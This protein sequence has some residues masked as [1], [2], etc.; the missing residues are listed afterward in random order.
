MKIFKKFPQWLFWL[1]VLSSLAV[2][3]L[4]S[5]G[6]FRMHDDL[7]V[8]RTYQ[9]H[10][11]VLD[12]QI[13]CRWVPDMGYGYGYPLF[14]YYPP[15]PYY[16]GE[17]IH[18]LGFDYFW[19]VK[20]VFILGF[21]ASGILMYLFAREFFG[22]LGGLISALF[23]IYA[24]YHALDIYVR[25]AMNEFW[26]LAWFPGI[27]WAAYKL[28]KEEKKEWLAILAFFWALLFMSH[29][30]MVMICAPVFAFWLFFL[31]FYF[32]KW[33]LLKQL[34]IA[35]LW[36][37]GLAGFFIIPTLLEKRF[38]HTETLVIGY[39]NY[40][41]HFADLNQMFISR[42]WGF[43]ASLWGPQDGMAFSVGHFHWLV[44]LLV[45]LFTF[46]IIWKNKIWKKW[47]QKKNFIWWLILLM[48]IIS[49]GSC[50]M[51]HYKSIFIW[52]RIKILEFAQFPWRFLTLATFSL[53]FLSGGIVLLFQKKP[54]VLLLITVLLILGVIF[55]NKNYFLPERQFQ[56]TAEEKF[57]GKYWMLQITA[58]IF[59]YLPVY[60][61]RPPGDPAPE[62]P[63][64]IE[65]EGKI[66]NWQ[67]GTNWAKFETEIASEKAKIRVPI[68]YYP[69]W[70]IWL[71]NEKANFSY[72]NELGL[73]TFEAEKGNHQVMIHLNNTPLRTIVNFL[74]IVS[75]AGLVGF[76]LEYRHGRN[77]RRDARKRSGD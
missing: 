6:Y 30:V 44:S 15:M 21:L 12:K 29:N 10:Q 32:N 18:L 50:F 34:F 41:A 54:R 17:I 22:H 27:F 28:I 9:M 77:K 37:V 31:L 65:G 2:L 42:F 13:P 20:I 60:A 23:Y 47:R 75:W 53:S 76:V 14:Q 66:E 73:P 62:E 58:G 48:A 40:M 35:G 52:Q 26:A 51:A 25:G 72:D 63:F 59:D 11:C 39:F 71:D 19:T 74:S 38:A 24:P 43:G 61:E 4:V 8:M 55:W 33:R 45:T 70:T 16:L 57:S 5:P 36:A 56:I 7:Q 64:F 1:I 3:P 67:K 69:N 68:F 49:L 46:L